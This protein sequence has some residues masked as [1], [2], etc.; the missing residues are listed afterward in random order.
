MSAGDVRRSL[1]AAWTAL[2]RC[3]L[4]PPP[5]AAAVLHTPRS[6]KIR[7]VVARRVLVAVVVA[8]VFFVSDL[9]VLDHLA[10]HAVRSRCPKWS[11][12]SSRRYREIVEI[13]ER[14]RRLLHLHG[15]LLRR[16]SR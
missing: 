16:G 15:R 6:S 2:G 3:L 11:T 7:V 8:V 14:G 10:V 9:I 12:V 4:G 1:F 5:S 13:D